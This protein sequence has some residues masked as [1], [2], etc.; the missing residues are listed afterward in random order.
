[1]FLVFRL[2]SVHQPL[3]MASAVF[4]AGHL[5]V[6]RACVSRRSCGAPVYYAGHAPSTPDRRCKVLRG[7]SWDGAIH[8][9]TS[10][11]E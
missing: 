9:Y 7:C 4:H 10:N 3:V 6:D 1:M 2:I 8:S 5:V 11:W